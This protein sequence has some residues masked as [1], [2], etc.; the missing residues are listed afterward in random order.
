MIVLTILVETSFLALLLSVKF[1]EPL[2]LQASGLV[3]GRCYTH[4][5]YTFARFPGSPDNEEPH[6]KKGVS[7]NELIIRLT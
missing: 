6:S 7:L 2:F 5:L 4:T 1:G 3:C